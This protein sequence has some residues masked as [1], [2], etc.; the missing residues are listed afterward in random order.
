MFIS[1]YFFVNSFNIRWSAISLFLLSP[2]IFS[3]FLIQS[4]IMFIQLLQSVIYVLVLLAFSLRKVWK[5]GIIYQFPIAMNGRHLVLPKGSETDQDH[6]QVCY[7]KWSIELNTLSGLD[8]RFSALILW[9]KPK[10]WK[11]S[12]CFVVSSRLFPK[13][14]S[15]YQR[16]RS[17]WETCKNNLGFAMAWWTSAIF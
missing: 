3:Y 13:V 17:R 10:A 9:Q 1:Q 7:P 8:T 12:N 14:S 5:P 11:H 6:D 4:M 2:F 15:Y 16:R